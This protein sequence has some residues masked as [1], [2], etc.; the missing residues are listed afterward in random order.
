MWF[1]LFP[2]LSR[3]GSTIKAKF[4][5]KFPARPSS[6]SSHGTIGHPKAA[7][8]ARHQ[9]SASVQGL[10][11]GNFSIIWSFS[12]IFDCSIRASGGSLLL[13]PWENQSTTA[14][15]RHGVASTADR[16]VPN[17]A[18]STNS[19]SFTRERV[20]EKGVERK[21]GVFM[22]RLIKYLVDDRWW[23]LFWASFDGIAI[24][25]TGRSADESKVGS[26]SVIW[27]FVTEIDRMKDLVIIAE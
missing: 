20:S 16:G 22:T 7:K 21:R 26:G 1:F 10:F 6:I 13:D 5:A 15:R 18:T 14:D 4:S 2:Q 17:T 8:L 19:N 23:S 25:A 3:K 24:S 11:L 12:L 27:S 9:H